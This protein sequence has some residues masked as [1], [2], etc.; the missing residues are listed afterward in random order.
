MEKSFLEKRIAQKAEK[1]FEK[2]WNEFIKFNSNNLI[3]KNIRIKQKYKDS[4]DKEIN[5]FN[6]GCNWAFFNGEQERNN[7]KELSNYEDVKKTLIE[8]FTG[9]ET[10]ILLNKMEELKYLINT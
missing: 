9:E 7:Q 4:E 3:G 2:E 8:K 6:F 10:E 5:V 1:R